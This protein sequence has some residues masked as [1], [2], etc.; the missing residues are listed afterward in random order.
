M[1]VFGN[2]LNVTTA[3]AGLS[4]LLLLGG[5]TAMSAG[6]AKSS[7]ASQPATTSTHTASYQP[8]S[9]VP[10]PPSTRINT[11]RSAIFGG[12]D[13]WYGRIVL[14]LDRAST[15]AYAYYQDQMPPFGWELV[16]AVQGKVSVLTFTRGDRAA[17]VEITPSALRGSEAVI[18]VSPRPATG[19]PINGGGSGQKK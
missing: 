4:A 5:C 16:S 2:C 13:R 18:T 1:K 8:V 11:E 12:G 10:I 9:D 6:G 17:S 19:A 15:M 14:S 3:T 7:G